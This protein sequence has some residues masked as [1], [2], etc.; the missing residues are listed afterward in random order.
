MK[1]SFEID[2]LRKNTEIDRKLSTISTEFKNKTLFIEKILST[3]S[4]E[5]KK[6]TSVLVDYNG[7]VIKIYI[8]INADW[9]V[10]QNNFLPSKGQYFL[11]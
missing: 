3:L 1:C 8:P 7:A 4:I 10:L 2:Y 9:A 5:K 6:K 11:N